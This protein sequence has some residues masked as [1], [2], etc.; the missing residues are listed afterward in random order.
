MER[1]RIQDTLDIDV[2][3]L[4]EQAEGGDV[5][6]QYQLGLCF[7]NGIGF[8]QDT[9]LAKVWLLKAASLGY[10]Q[11]GRDLQWIDEASLLDPHLIQ[12][13]LKEQLFVEVDSPLQPAITK[14]ASEPRFA[15][16][17]EHLRVPVHAPFPRK[18]FQPRPMEPGG[19]A[20]GTEYLISGHPLA[21]DGHKGYVPSLEYRDPIPPYRSS[22][23]NQ[24]AGGM[25]VGTGYMLTHLFHRNRVED[26]VID[27]KNPGFLDRLIIGFHHQ[28]F[29]QYSLLLGCFIVLIMVISVGHCIGRFDRFV[30]DASEMKN[31]T[32]VIYME[33]AKA[34][35]LGVSKE[36]INT[37]VKDI[38]DNSYGR[39]D[40]KLGCW[41][42]R[43]GGTEFCIKVNRVDAVRTKEGSRV[44]VL[45][46]GRMAN[47]SNLADGII[48]MF[49]LE[50]QMAGNYTTVAK[51]PFVKAGTGDEPPENW[52][53]VKLGKDDVWGWQGEIANNNL[54]ETDSG[55]LLF[56][57]IDGNIKNIGYIPTA[58]EMLDLDHV[59][60][61]LANA[62]Q[63]INLSGTIKIE[64]NNNGLFY[65]IRL[66]V[67]GMKNGNPVQSE[68]VR[69]NFKE[70][71]GE[72][73]IPMRNPFTY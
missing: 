71:I 6:A 53:F 64:E 37:M 1:N 33:G 18:D 61:Q 9:L 59:N 44:Y 56:T 36:D 19:I 21:L 60:S 11:A 67:S 70:D 49:I 5:V 68:S 42:S 34:T 47:D 69:I 57:Q 51:N 29:H 46:T 63:A 43:S 16:L 26:T 14:T 38:M 40:S 54:G 58:L 55:V 35:P 30:N 7:L 17:P 20:C 23:K 8:R 2:F 3:H 48:G 39:F 52:Q 13:Y 73:V 22:K 45:A 41:S 66:T 32:K 12:Q 15:P 72:Y 25:P 50:P 62:R 24:D 10:A 4:Y 27:H 28:K 31:V 65:P